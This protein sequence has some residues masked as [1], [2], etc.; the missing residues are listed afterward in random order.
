MKHNF[1]LCLHSR[2]KKQ[3]KLSDS[4]ATSRIRNKGN[5]RNYNW[6][7]VGRLRL[8]KVFLQYPMNI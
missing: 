5:T 6:T 8:D 7:T 3:K 1:A 4:G 2:K